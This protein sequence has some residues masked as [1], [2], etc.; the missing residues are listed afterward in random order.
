[1]IR[2]GDDTPIHDG[3]QAAFAFMKGLIAKLNKVKTEAEARKALRAFIVVRREF[4]PKCTMPKLDG[5]RQAVEFIRERLKAVEASP[6]AVA[7]WDELS[8]VNQ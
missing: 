6:Q 7:L 4:V 1:M 5:A 8:N 3:S 2:R